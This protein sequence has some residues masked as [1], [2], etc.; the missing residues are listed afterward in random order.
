VNG[1]YCFIGELIDFLLSV[2][3]DRLQLIHF[4]FDRCLQGDE[5]DDV[6]AAP[7][8]LALQSVSSIR[9]CESWLGHGPVYVLGS[10]CS[11]PHAPVRG[12]VQL[13]AAAIALK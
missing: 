11:I 12:V 5:C 9:Q 8:M 1:F 7:A 10:A 6:W 13:N 2:C 3:I 4:L